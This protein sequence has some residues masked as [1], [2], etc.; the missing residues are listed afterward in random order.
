MF[1]YFANALLEPRALFE[2]DL[3]TQTLAVYIISIV[4]VI[5][6]VTKMVSLVNCCSLV[7]YLGLICYCYKRHVTI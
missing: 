7:I 1:C 4:Y 2:M 6:M 3:N 5:A